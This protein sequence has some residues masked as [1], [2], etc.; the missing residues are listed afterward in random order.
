MKN[1]DLAQ[2]FADGCAAM[3]GLRDGIVLREAAEHVLD[4]LPAG[5]L[6]FVSSSVEGAAL[7]AVCAT[8]RADGSHWCQVN[9]LA[10]TPDKSDPVVFVEPAFPGRAWQDAINRAYPGCM[11]RIAP[12][13]RSYAS[14][15][16]LV[17]SAAAAA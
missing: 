1:V 3:C 13:A 8:L 7:A 4:D 11:T 12:G 14:S 16:R 9:L 15:D 2:H 5:R 10:P 6:A 17:A